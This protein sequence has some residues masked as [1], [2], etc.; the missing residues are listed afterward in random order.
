M[1]LQYT[2][3]VLVLLSCLII[4]PCLAIGIPSEE[5][6]HQGDTIPYGQK[7]TYIDRSVVQ[8]GKGFLYLLSS[9]NT[10]ISYAGAS[11]NTYS[12]EYEW[13]TNTYE[14]KP[15]SAC[16]GGYIDGN[17]ST[18][19]GRYYSCADPLSNTGT[20]SELVNYCS[21][22]FTVLPE[23]RSSAN[24]SIDSSSGNSAVYPDGD[25]M[26]L[27]PRELVNVP[28]GNP[29]LMIRL[30]GNRDSTSVVTVNPGDQ[31]IN[32]ELTA[33]QTLSHAAAPG[34]PTITT[35]PPVTPT[36]VPVQATTTVR[37][38]SNVTSAFGNLLG[39]IRKFFGL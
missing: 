23:P 5:I 12:Y 37:S 32:A 16:L 9:D 7:I 8:C 30:D 33:S 19:P 28:T 38:P 22:M 31:T 20:T 35:N 26:G 17:I 13:A 15:V 25:G 14:Q 4:V 1:N 6:I 21:L 36:A 11:F 34:S 24:I 10:T 2:L 39:S 27:A 18:S 3:F 29:T